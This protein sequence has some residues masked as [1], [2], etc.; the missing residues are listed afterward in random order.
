MKSK[1]NNRQHSTR[2]TKRIFSNYLNKSTSIIA[3]I[4]NICQFVEQ[5]GLNLCLPIH[6]QHTNLP[7]YADDFNCLANIIVLD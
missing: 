2:Q 5:C 7:S 4:P 3:N 6:F 1:K